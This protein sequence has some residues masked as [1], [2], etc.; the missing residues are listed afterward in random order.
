MET[1]HAPPC[2]HRRTDARAWLDQAWGY[3]RAA[4]SANLSNSGR[5]TT[6]GSVPER[7][8]AQTVGLS[9]DALISWCTVCAGTHGLVRGVDDRV[10]LLLRDVPKNGGDDGHASSLP[11]NTD[12][13]AITPPLEVWVL[14]LLAVESQYFLMG[15]RGNLFEEHDGDMFS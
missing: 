15:H 12:R 2:G 8:T 7:V 11:G 14:S 1:V 6:I 13:A 9:A 3:S 4:D 10:N 5:F